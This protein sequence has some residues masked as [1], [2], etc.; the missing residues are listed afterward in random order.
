MRRNGTV[1]FILAIAFAASAE[2]ITLSGTV[3]NKSGKAISGA[4]VKLSSRNLADTTD[5][6]GTFSITDK[7]VLVNAAPIQPCAEKISLNNNTILFSLTKP[8]AVGIELFDT[9]GR[10]LEKTFNPAAP[11]G[12]YRFDL[13]T[14]RVTANFMIIRASIG[15]HIATFRYLSL[16]DAKRSAAFLI[17]ATLTE[18]MR[19]LAK[20]QSSLD[21]LKVSASGYVSR[22]VPINSYITEVTIALDSISL[23][24]FSFFITSLSALQILSKNE[25]GFGGDF[26]FGKTGQGAGLSGADSICQC[27]AE[28]SMPNSKIKQWRAFLSVTKDASGNKVNAIERIGKGPWYDRLGR[29]VALTTQD[30]LNARPANCDAVIK[31]DLPNEDGVPNHY[32]DPNATS[33]VD[34]HHMVTGSNTSGQL[35][36]ASSVSTCEDWTSV[37]AKGKPRCGFS[38]PRSNKDNHWISGWDAAGCEPSVEADAQFGIGG[39]GGYGG[40]YCFALNP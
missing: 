12:D 3:S 8:A 4:I 20:A 25:K 31:N 23:P 6:Q 16:L 36:S 11:T 32:P 24:H 17:I 9:R 15:T 22:D 35:Y 18:E 2:T 1:F 38:W 40:F 34:N 33:P 28:M 5:S 10:L 39:G 26:R 37:T 7:T 14:H 29:V 27:I 30:L 21:S 19:G 13:M